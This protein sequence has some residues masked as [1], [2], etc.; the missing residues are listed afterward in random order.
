MARVTRASGHSLPAFKAWWES[1]PQ[2]CV[3]SGHPADYFEGT[4]PTDLPV[5]VREE[6]VQY[7]AT[8]RDI[9]RAALVTS[10]VFRGIPY[11]KLTGKPKHAEV[12]VYNTN[13][14]IM[15]AAPGGVATTN[16]NFSTNFTTTNTFTIGAGMQQAQVHVFPNLLAHP[17]QG[18]AGTTPIALANAAGTTAG[19]T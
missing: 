19:I 9:Q 11:W 8:K 7:F 6:V 16:V 10:M 15:M 4:D 2:H 1:L 17:M 14:G 18:T 5:S 12:G 3:E 13:G